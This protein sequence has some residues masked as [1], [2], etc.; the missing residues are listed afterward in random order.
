[1]SRNRII[2]RADFRGRRL[3]QVEI[4]F[5]SALD[6]NLTGVCVGGS[7]TLTG[8]GWMDCHFFGASAAG[9][10]VEMDRF[11][12]CHMGKLKLER[13]ILWEVS[14]VQCDFGCGKWKEMQLD[15]CSFQKCGFRDF[16][17]AD[18]VLTGTTFQ[19]CSFD[20]AVWERTSFEE[21]LFRN[22]HFQGEPD[23][24]DGCSFQGCTFER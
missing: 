17:M 18:C 2:R 21:V 22:C 12:R 19:E 7:G 8:N 4:K 5:C 20:R 23:F 14:A 16:H 6:T 13:A 11:E 9:L 1:M 10:R 24:P 3:E 15:G